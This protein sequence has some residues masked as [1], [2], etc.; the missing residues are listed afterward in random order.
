MSR[1]GLLAATVSAL[2]FGPSIASAQEIEEVVVTAQKREET[3]Q[4]VPLSVSAL[5][6]ETLE[7]ANI[8]S[9]Q[10][11]TNVTP[12]LVFGQ[13]GYAAMPSV[14]GVGTKSPG[15]GDESIVPLYIDGVYQSALASYFFEF[16]SIKRIEV[17][18]GPQGTLFGRNAVGGAI[19]IITEDPSENP[20][21]KMSATYASFNERAADFYLTGGLIPGVSANISIHADADD[22]Y[23]D[24]LVNGETVARSSSFA[25]RSKLMWHPTDNSR[26]K[27]AVNYINSHDNTASSGELLDG[28]TIAKNVD[29]DV[30]IA[31]RYETA[32]TYQGVFPMKQLSFALDGHV[33]LDAFDI[34]AVGGWVDSKFRQKVDQD[35]TPIDY[36]GTEYSQFDTSYSG[37]VRLTSN[38]D[39]R[40]QWIGGVFVFFDKAGYGND[41]LFVSRAS[42]TG[43]TTRLK[44]A[45]HAKAYAVFGEV[46]YDVTDQLSVTGGLRYNKEERDIMQLRSSTP[47]G[48]ATPVPLAPFSEAAAEFEKVT[49]RVTVEYEFSDNFRTYATYSQ[50]FKSGLYNGAGGVPEPVVVQPEVLDAYEMGLKSEPLRNMRFNAAAYY[51]DYKDVQVQAIVNGVNALQNAASA[52]I[53]GV[54]AELVLAATEYWNISAAANYQK[55]RFED[56]PGAI[57]FPARPNGRGNVSTI[58]DASGNALIRSPDF[59]FSLSSDYTVPVSFGSLRFSGNY[60]YSAEQFWDNGNLLRQEP[61]SNINGRVTWFSPKDDVRVS[62]FGENLTDDDRARFM[63]NSANNSYQVRIRPRTIGIKLEYFWN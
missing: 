18:K 38:T 5:S 50:G 62:I 9:T 25:V 37:E 56:F 21:A 1:I 57:T 51:Y 63:L 28:V 29:P 30:L 19:N 27:A 40:L 43:A 24:N 31:G 45:T 55:A 46:T 26:L 59:T 7:K 34:D 39:S 15:P 11:L 16:N 12:G 20:S 6:G 47:F 14:R 33:S 61:Y 60:Y 48:A 49:P 42:P 10:Q 41:G 44:V 4:E 52:T 32:P 23:I 53:K 22:G 35:L 58:A 2:A 17:L 54:E 36:A 8:T 13:T 3:L